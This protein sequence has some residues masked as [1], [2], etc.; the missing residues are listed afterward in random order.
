MR[1]AHRVRHPLD[2]QRLAPRGR[3]RLAL[4]LRLDRVLE[5]PEIE[6]EAGGA[7]PVLEEHV[8]E[9]ERVLAPRHRHQHGLVRA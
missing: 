1:R 9:R 2:V 7:V 8:P 6:I 4:G 3:E 5:D